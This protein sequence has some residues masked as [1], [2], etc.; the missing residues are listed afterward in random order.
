[1]HPRLAGEDAFKQLLDELAQP[2][3]DEDSPVLK[4]EYFVEDELLINITQHEL[5]PKHQVITEEEKTQ[6]L[7]TDRRSLLRTARV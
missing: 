1:M 3:E 7:K 2:R 4:I 6:L 5:V